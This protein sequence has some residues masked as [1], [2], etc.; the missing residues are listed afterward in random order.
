MD[1]LNL[2]FEIYVPELHYH[3]NDPDQVS[4]NF[5]FCKSDKF[6]F[7]WLDQP[8]DRK[9]IPIQRKTN[10]LFPHSN[11]KVKFDHDLT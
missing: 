5:D 7:P 4:E 6:E 8:I 2:N 1:M 3:S 10:I 9:V 11:Q